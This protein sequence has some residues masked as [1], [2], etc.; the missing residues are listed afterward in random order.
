MLGRPADGL[1]GPNVAG[2]VALLAG[3][4]VELDA[5]ALIEALVARAL[6]GREV[7]EHV[8][9]PLT[10]DEAVTLLGFEEL[11]RTA[12]QLAHFPP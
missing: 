10:R 5:L 9:A 4:D 2:F 8:V 12:G 6:N 1:D 3:T 11:H 7:D